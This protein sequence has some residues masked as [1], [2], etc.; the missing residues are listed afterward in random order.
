MPLTW[1]NLRQRVLQVPQGNPSSC[2]MQN[3]PSKEQS[4]S[5][6]QG[7]P[8]QMPDQGVASQTSPPSPSP[9][10]SSELSSE[11]LELE[12]LR[13]DARVDRDLQD[14]PTHR[15]GP[16]VGCDFF[17]HGERPL[18]ADLEGALCTFEPEFSENARY[19]LRDSHGLALSAASARCHCASE[20]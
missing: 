20:S 2:V 18:V 4:P 12:V 10:V 13:P 7:S 1:M 6:S 11:E 5:I 15:N 16:R 19:G 8:T 14:V 17:A 9:F 3:P